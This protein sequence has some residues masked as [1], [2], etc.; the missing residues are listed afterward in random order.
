[1]KGRG[2]TGRNP[3][4]GERKKRIL[5]VDDHPMIRERISEVIESESDLSVCGLAA[6]RGEALKAAAETKP[7]LAIVDLTLRQSHGL[8]LIKDLRSGYPNL[9]VL[10]VSMHDETFHAERAIRA[11][12]RGYIT[13]QEA[14]YAVLSAIRTVLAGQVYLSKE[15]ALRL[16][17]RVARSST[18]QP[19]LALAKLTDRELLVLTML[20]QGHG[21]RFIAEELKVHVSTIE[22]YRARIKE[23][24]QL[25]N[26]DDLRRFAIRFVQDPES[27]S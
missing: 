21:T 9:L 26:A 12:A 24:F 16:A 6:D 8:D 27:K 23:K 17:S 19:E 11:G 5:I 14:T 1:V 20:G 18:T 7:D 10:V 4:N 22:T 3:E 2:K 25:K 15:M 13:K